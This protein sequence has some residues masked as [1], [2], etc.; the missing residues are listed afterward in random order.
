[1]SEESRKN[2]LQLVISNIWH[3]SNKEY[4]KRVWIGGKGPEGDDFDETSMYILDEGESL[5]QERKYLDI[6]DHQYNL[7]KTFWNEYEAFCDKPGLE[8]YLLELFIDT[9]EW[10]KITELAKEVIKAFDYHYVFPSI[11]M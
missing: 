7:L 10:T 3:V 6:T 5:L 11:K 8:H 2:M 1:M 9:Q 4:Q